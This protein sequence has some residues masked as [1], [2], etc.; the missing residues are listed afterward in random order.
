MGRTE[1]LQLQ[2]PPWTPALP[3]AGPWNSGPAEQGTPTDC[4]R[5]DHCP[6]APDSLGQRTSQSKF[7]DMGHLAKRTSGEWL[8]TNL[9]PAPLA[10]R[11]GPSRPFAAP[12]RP[13]G[14][15][16]YAAEP[17]DRPGPRARPARGLA[18]PGHV[19]PPRANQRKR[20]ASCCSSPAG[21][22]EAAVSS[23]PPCAPRFQTPAPWG[24]SALLFFL[25]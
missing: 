10:T 18:A 15:R 11:D 4:T 19:S 20:R 6:R 7:T 3:P 8:T 2:R 24:C 14:P 17:P 1:A 21:R 25:S 16:L 13:T 9:R 22:G 12:C 23:A 5:N